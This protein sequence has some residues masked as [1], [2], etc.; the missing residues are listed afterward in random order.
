M[1]RKKCHL[2]LQYRSEEISPGARAEVGNITYHTYY[3]IMFCLTHNNLSSKTQNSTIVIMCSNPSYMLH[4][5]MQLLNLSSCMWLS[6]CVSLCLAEC[7]SYIYKPLK[8]LQVYEAKK[9]YLVSPE[10]NI[11]NV[12]ISV[13]SKILQIFESW[14][15]Y[16]ICICICMIYKT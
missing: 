11:L 7:P 12:S 4:C 6:P 16:F 15:F 8:C 9:K 10:T 1:F 14:S 5:C 3:L 13:R 2:S